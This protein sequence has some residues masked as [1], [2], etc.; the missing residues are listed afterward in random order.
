VPTA[1]RVF[2]NPCPQSGEGDMA[3]WT[4]GCELRATCVEN[5]DVEV[6]FDLWMHP[7]GGGFF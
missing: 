6:L 2:A 7:A 3:G 1:E 5:M 4:G